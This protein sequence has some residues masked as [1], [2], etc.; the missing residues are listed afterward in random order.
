VLFWN[1][2][3]PFAAIVGFVLLANHYLIDVSGAQSVRSFFGVLK[4]SESQ[5]GRYRLLSHGT[6]LHGGQRIRDYDGNPVTGRPE[7]I[8]Y[9]YDGSGM[10]QIM[11]AV[12]E[13]SNPLSYAVIGLGTGTL[14]CRAQPGDKV[15]Y[16]EIDPAII[17]IANDPSLFTYISECGPVDIKIGDARLT[18]DEAPDEAYDVILVDAFSSDAIPIHLLTREA[19]AIYRKKLKPH[20]IV[21]IHVSNR[22]L[23]LASVVAGIAAANGMVARVNEGADVTENDAEYQFLGTV[24]AVARSDD[25]FG[26]IAKSQYW[27]LQEPD[28]DQWVWTDDYSNVIG[29]VV[30]RYRE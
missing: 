1:D 12:R 25:D 20:G 11:D 23:E 16:Y 3:V 27:E 5:D 7:P 19:M 22:H 26:R 8:M 4:I 15:T 14:A 9:Y 13:R 24:V 30:R 28:P 21:S 29:A 6:T 17:R 10:A 2:P 18:L